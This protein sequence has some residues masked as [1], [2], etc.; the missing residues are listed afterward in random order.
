MEASQ[1]L[2]CLL[3]F[4]FHID[5]SLSQELISCSE[6]VSSPKLCLTG[7]GYVTPVDIVE[8]L[9]IHVQTTADLYDIINVDTE[10]HSMTVHLDLGL[11]WN[12][13][14]ISY[15]HF[16]FPLTQITIIFT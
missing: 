13:T 6:P 12:D 11:I 3:L 8:D 1:T 10:K 2:W 14:S 16:R 7:D 4:S 5:K 15:A 9:P